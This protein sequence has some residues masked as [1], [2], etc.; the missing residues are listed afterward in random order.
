M[1]KFNGRISFMQYM[2]MKPIKR[3]FKF[4]SLCD[5]ESRYCMR[6]R[7]YSG[8]EARFV[9]GE[10]FT[11]NMVMELLNNYLYRSHILYTDN[12][13]TSIKLAIAL[14]SMDTHLVGTIRKTSKSF[15]KLDTVSLGVGDN[16][17]LVNEAGVVV[18]R[19]VDKR[20]VY[21]LSTVT[22]GSDVDVPMTRLLVYINHIQSTI[23]YKIHLFQYPN[24]LFTI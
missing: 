22:D 19:F 16:I 23:L 15:P 7:I 3:G 8:S 11:Y 20:D 6:L 1:I 21:T 14:R 4:F 17:K 18:C 9:S 5:S 10:G 12:Y 2:P 13:Y 24:Y